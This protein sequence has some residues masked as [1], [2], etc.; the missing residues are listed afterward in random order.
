MEPTININDLIITKKCKQEDIKQGDII[1][2]KKGDTIIT[3]R[4]EKIFCT[5]SLVFIVANLLYYFVQIV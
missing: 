1:S 2:Y 5:V 4:I 3:H